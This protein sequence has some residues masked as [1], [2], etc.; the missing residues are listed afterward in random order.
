M[1]ESPSEH[2]IYRP[3]RAAGIAYVLSAIL[4]AMGI[5]CLTFLRTSAGRVVLGLWGCGLG[6]WHFLASWT[7]LQTHF[8]VTRAGIALVGPRYSWGMEW[9][10]VAEV[11][12]RERPSV[13]WIGRADRLVV[14][15]STDGRKLPLNTSVLSRAEEELLLE[16]IRRSA[17][18]PVR[19]LTESP[20]GPLWPGGRR[21]S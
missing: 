19:K 3:A 1:T 12:I 11:L 9:A 15:T 13:V 4:L 14:L 17:P 20:L 8:L 18:C 2:H 16:E 10:E 6:V 21:E 5:S 7:V